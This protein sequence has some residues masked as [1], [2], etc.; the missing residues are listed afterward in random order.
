MSLLD[1]YKQSLSRPSR[2]FEQTNISH[3]KDALAGNLNEY[4]MPEI[5]SESPAGTSNYKPSGLSSYGSDPLGYSQEDSSSR[6]LSS[7]VGTSYTS[8]GRALTS[9]DLPYSGMT[10][11]QKTQ[12]YTGLGTKALGVASEWSKAL[13]YPTAGQYLGKAAEAGSALLSAYSAYNIAQG[14]AHAGDYVNVA[15][16][17]A[18]YGLGADIG[19]YTGG[20]LGI[21]NIAK[22]S[23]NP[24]DYTAATSGALSAGAELAALSAYGEGLAGAGG[25][26]TSATASGAGTASAGLGAGASAVGAMGAGYLA[27]AL[28]DYAGI[29]DKD[30]GNTRS[31]TNVGA[32]GV[33]GYIAGGPMGVPFGIAGGSLY[34]W[35]SPDEDPIAIEQEKMVN[36]ASALQ[37][38][39]TTNPSYVYKASEAPV[40][41][42]SRDLLTRYTTMLGDPA[43]IVAADPT[44]YMRDKIESGNLPPVWTASS[45]VKTDA[46]VK[47]LENSWGLTDEQVNEMLQNGTLETYIKNYQELENQRRLQMQN[48]TAMNISNMMHYGPAYTYFK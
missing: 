19:P 5:V 16:T 23:Q 13:G 21:Y 3:A 8:T 47:A 39:Y 36:Y 48:Y 2:T 46:D 43:E 42:T 20:A 12:T 18:K 9:T 44:T 30:F 26:A 27:P 37:N 17:T 6:S 7:N 1:A 15:G 35:F 10:D 33:A 24:L 28:L 40:D 45:T 14:Q 41:F 11:W 31:L 38:Y 32:G 22:G 29:T 25:A 4:Q 34:D